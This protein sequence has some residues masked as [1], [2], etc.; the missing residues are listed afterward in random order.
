MIDFTGLGRMKIHELKGRQCVQFFPDVG[1][2]VQDML[3][4]L[5][6]GLKKRN[7][8]RGILMQS[9]SS[10]KKGLPVPCVIIFGEENR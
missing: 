2:T 1:K 7:Q 8:Y 10:K 4:V 6:E 3:K 5:D 9:E